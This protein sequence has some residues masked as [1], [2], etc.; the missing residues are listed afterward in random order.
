MNLMKKRS[1]VWLL[2][3]F[4]VCC[5][6]FSVCAEDDLQ[7]KPEEHSFLNEKVIV[8]SIKTESKSQFAEIMN[9]ET[10]NNNL[11]N[12]KTDAQKEIFCKLKIKWHPEKKFCGEFSETGEC[13]PYF[14]KTGIGER[15]ILSDK[16]YISIEQSESELTCFQRFKAFLKGKKARDSIL[17]GMWSKHFNSSNDHRETHNLCGLQYNGFYAATFSNSHSHQVFSIGVS[18]TLTEKRTGTGFLLDAGYKIGPMYGYKKGVPR[19]SRFSILPVFCIGIS[20]FNVGVDLNIFPA[21]AVS[22]N[23]HINIK[24]L[25]K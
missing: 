6:N 19:I 8:F 23:T 1:V 7:L 18:R 16:Q 20:Y 3:I 12:I 21:N 15:S 5:R 9:F 24:P 4:L 10:D 14:Y 25:S 17:A 22:F 11:F 2:V 13:E